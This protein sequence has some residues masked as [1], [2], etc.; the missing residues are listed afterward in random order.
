MTAVQRGE[1]ARDPAELV[2]EAL[3]R[4]DE[5]FLDCDAG[6]RRRMAAATREVLDAWL[7]DEIRARLPVGHRM[8]AFCVRH[9]LLDELARLISDEAA[10]R[11]E[12]AVVVG[13]R[14]YAV[15]PYLRGV[16]RQDADITA[17]VGVEHRLT[18]V[19]WTGGALRIRGRA[20]IE[21]V[22]ARDTSVE[23]VVRDRASGA[24]LRVA[25]GPDAPPAEPAAS[26]GHPES[27]RHPES[28]GQPGSPG[29]P[30]FGG[31]PGEGGA[32]ASFVA[33]VPL[34]ALRPG[35]WEVDVSVR[36]LGLT[37]RAPLGAA[38]F[39][40][41][42]AGPGAGPGAGSPTASWDRPEA[43]AYFTADGA[44]AIAVPGRGG[45]FVRRWWR[46]LTRRGATACG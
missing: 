35:Q 15:Y 27:E 25:A 19:S 44:L 17:E 41:P 14:V 26:A 46:R 34:A 9:D 12:G 28:A 16:S 7:T 39:A 38:G 2:R 10:G 21:R 4:Y 6:R 43:T 5:R 29:R 40:G 30:G 45:R 8:R 36:A 3:G 37:R 20:G 18:E 13:G 32:G 23:I 11:R 24:E 1:P 31:R 22:A 33:E 42:H